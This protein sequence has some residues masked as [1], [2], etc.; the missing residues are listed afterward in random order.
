[1]YRQWAPYVRVADRR[2]H[3]AAELDQLKRAGHPVSPVVIEGRAI[4]TTAWGKAWCANLEAYGDYA[5]RLPRGRTYVRNGSVVDL[6]IAAGRV[7][8]RVSGSSV[9]RVSVTIQPLPA[10]RWRALCAD[11]AGG[12][13]SLV[14]L[15][16][17]RLAKGVMERLCRARD[18]LFPAPAEIKLACSCPD[19][20]MMCKHVAAVLY[21][22]GAR[23]DHR[24]EL[25]FTL[26][27]V[28]AS[29]LLANAGQAL[30]TA[31]AA[32]GLALADDDLSALFGLD[33]D[34]G[35]PVAVVAT[36]RGA[37]AA[38]TAPVASAVGSKGAA[39]RGAKAAPGAPAASSKGAAGRGAKA[40]PVPAAAKGTAA[41]GVKAAGVAAVAPA[42]A[43]KGAA[44]RAAKAAAGAP[45]AASG[46][47]SKG[48][49]VAS[50][51]AS[52]GA[53]GRVTTAAA[54][55]PAVAPGGRSK[56]AA[57]VSAAAPAHPATSAVGWNPGS[58]EAEVEAAAARVEVGLIKLMLQR[59]SVSLAEAEAALGVGV[60]AAL[61]E[62]VDAR[63]VVEVGATGGTRFKLG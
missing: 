60:G 10:S 58:K 37:K 40:G 7:D 50:T 52:K 22:V 36:G 43:S 41:A 1:M 2:R 59:G 38:L 19:G 55:A 23:L 14:E 28:D 31:P 11:C 46:V 26:R 20:A 39:G 24:P 9:Y 57:A 62:L 30:A 6:Q 48:V 63:R 21:G 13:D 35:E 4:A 27:Q 15:L 44:G 18:G 56:G 5:N 53:A 34:V 42:A 49:A 25:L 12:I 51:T 54:G 45:K 3:A 16:Q 29:E 32:D 33:L 61:Q 17:G 47:G 8:A